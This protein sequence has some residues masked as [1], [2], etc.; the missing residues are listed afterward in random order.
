MF[1]LEDIPFVELDVVFPEEAE[2]FLLER[3]SPVMLLLILD[4]FSQAV[5][6]RLANRE[7]TVA[8]LP[9]EFSPRQTLVM[10]PF[11]RVGLD[12]TQHVGDRNRRAAALRA[13]VL[14]EF[15]PQAGLNVLPGVLLILG[16]ARPLPTCGTRAGLAAG[17][18]RSVEPVAIAPW[19]VSEVISEEFTS[20]PAVSRRTSTCRPRC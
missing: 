4:V 9:L 17:L 20:R 15:G 11:A 7:S 3:L 14:G 16:W 1:L 13:D 19:G 12:Q 18:E 5:N 6:L 10:N 2:K 8:C